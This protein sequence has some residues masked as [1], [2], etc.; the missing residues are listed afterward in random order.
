[1][2]IGQA[3]ALA[4]DVEWWIGLAAAVLVAIADYLRRR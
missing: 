1:M 2:I 3:L 4:D